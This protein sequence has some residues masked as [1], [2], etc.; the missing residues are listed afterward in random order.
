MIAD[1]SDHT[2]GV[3]IKTPKFTVPHPFDPP[4]SLRVPDESNSCLLFANIFV[5]ANVFLLCGQFLDLDLDRSRGILL[6]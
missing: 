5:A 1:F 6:N 2:G 4:V 3:G